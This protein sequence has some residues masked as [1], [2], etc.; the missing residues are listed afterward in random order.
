MIDECGKIGM[1]PLCDSPSYCKADAKSVYIGQTHHFAHM[2]HRNVDSY[3]PSGWS[4]LKGKFPT[5]FCTY[6][7][8]AGGAIQTLCTTGGSHSWQRVTGNNEIMCAK[9]PEYVPDEPFSG[10]L[11]EKNGA[12]AG[13]YT[14]Q[15]VRTTQTS[16]NYDTIMVDECAK[17]GMKPLCDYP[18]YCK[19]DAK[20]VYIGQAHHIAH[21]P[22]RNIDSYF[23]SG[24]SD[25][26]GKFPTT[27]CTYT[28]ASGGA[29]Q[30][31]C[32]TGG[33]SHSWQKVTGNNEIMCAKAPEY[34]PDEP[35]SGTLGEKN[36]ADE[37]EYTFQ[38][39][40]TSQTSGNYDTIMIDEC[41]KIGMKP[42]CDNP[43]YCK[44][45]ANSVYIGQTYHIAHTPH[46]NIDS[47]FPSGWSDVKG[48]FPTT[49]CTYTGASGGAIQT[50]CTTGGGSQSWQKVTGN[51]EIM[52]AIAPPYVPD[53]P[54]SGSLGEKNGA[55]AGTYTFQRVRTSQTS[56]NYDSIMIDECGKIGMKPLCDH[57]SYC[58]SDA[59][60][61]YIGQTNNIA[62]TSHRNIDS[63]F[64]SGWSDV[65]G[66]FPDTFCTYTGAAGGASKTLCTTGGGG[67]AWQAVTANNE[68]MCAKAP[69]YVPDEPFSGT[70]GEKSGA[71]GGKYTFQRVRTSQTSGNYDTIMINECQKIGMKPLCD[72]PSYC[73]NDANSVYIGQTYHIAHTPHRNIDSYFPSGWSDVK[74]NF[75]TTFCTYT[76]A[77]G[78]ASKTL[79]TTG[80]SHSW[81][82]VTGNNEI[83][84]AKAPPY[85]PDQPFSGFLG[86][87]NGAD[88]GKYTFQRVRA[89]QT[90]GNYDT[91]MIN[92]CQKIGMKP[93]C[94]HPSYCKTDSKSGYIGQNH[95]IAH[96]PHRNIDSY[97]PSGWSDIKG[98][99]PTTFCT[100]TGAAGGA[101]QT[102]C[103]TGG[104]HAWQRA[105]ANNEIMCVEMP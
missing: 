12:D 62:H 17:I 54:F 50:L 56:G 93:L 6:T 31:L 95:H 24:W 21:T 52:C 7:G 77:S 104:G 16:G 9:E 65:K 1:K 44:N 43:S 88:A 86:A 69:K 55:D 73:K 33:G 78:G 105:T 2:P 75:P 11:G 66:N 34:V 3:F 14:F 48:K 42:L 99:F 39:V 30:T 40:R 25:V 94:D 70:L 28:G 72:N 20:S 89:S 58:K 103:T 63:Y 45:D 32:T 85:I 68:I 97:F 102:L 84:C 23:P 82:S 83:M 15:R 76:G 92:E 29:I 90:S 36:G 81:Q 100:Y 51:N 19:L 98:N 41:Q 59:N 35:F 71:D 27:F 46:R 37:G 10:S 96:T 64:P 5:T 74:G 80:G 67:H 38:R 87:K 18:S 79:C 91:I 60:S 101:I 49:F 57:P 53:K 26:K 13:T 8:T 22:H 4:D 61:V 47:Y